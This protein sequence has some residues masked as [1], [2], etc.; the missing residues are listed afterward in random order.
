MNTKNL[1]WQKFNAMLEHYHIDKDKPIK[2]LSKREIH[3]M[4]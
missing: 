2:K 4:M 1:E 3:L